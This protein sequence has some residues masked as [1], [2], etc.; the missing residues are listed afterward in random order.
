MK[1][2]CSQIPNYDARQCCEN[3]H[4]NRDSM[5]YGVM[6]KRVWYRVC[7]NAWRYAKKN[8]FVTSTSV[9]ETKK[10]EAFSEKNISIRLN[11]V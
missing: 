5:V 3:C 9:G 1:L 2:N 4:D 10:S 7:C 6:I 11:H 8:R